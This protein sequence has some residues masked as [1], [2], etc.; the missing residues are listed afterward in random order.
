MV[1]KRA[2]SLAVAGVGLLGLGVTTP[3]ASGSATPAPVFNEC[4]LIAPPC[5]EGLWIDGAPAEMFSPS[6]EDRFI[7]P[8]AECAAWN[9][10]DSAQKGKGFV[11]RISASASEN[12]MMRNFPRFNGATSWFVAVTP[13]SKYC[14]WVPDGRLS[15][16]AT[17][18]PEWRI[19]LKIQLMGPGNALP[20][21]AMSNAM[22]SYYLLNQNNDGSYSVELEASPTP[23]EVFDSWTVGSVNGKPLYVNPERW[24]EACGRPDARANRRNPPS[25]NI[26]LMGTAWTDIAYSDIDQLKSRS[27]LMIASNYGCGDYPTITFNSKT[28]SLSAA[29]SAPHFTSTG[30]INT[31][32]FQA[33]LPAQYLVD[34]LGISVA[35]ALSGGLTLTKVVDGSA[36]MTLNAVTELS[37]EGHVSVK[38]DSFH[39]SSPK[40]TL[41]TK[42]VGRKKPKQELSSRVRSLQRGES[43][44]IQVQAPGHKD[45]SV[46]LYL[47]DK[48]DQYHFIGRADVRGRNT[49]VVVQI[50]PDIRRGRA[51]LVVSYGSSGQ[52]RGYNT[53]VPVVIR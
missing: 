40:F 42:V 27:G 33:I 29:I 23:R 43:T 17:L 19:R 21:N 47:V 39:Y 48:S 2:I 30:E 26:H 6:I 51:Q 8:G 24:L 53:K 3:R 44:N 45:G 52:L 10:P 36:P 5:I 35:D 38:V 50:P 14:R 32:F 9:V 18:N 28:R 22:M 11:K 7:G 13:I 37:P 4:D 20:L 41:R 16:E 49:N 1:S 12:P 25:I 46:M 15:P 31:G 34:E